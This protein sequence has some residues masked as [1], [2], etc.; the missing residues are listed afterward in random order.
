MP[1]ALANIVQARDVTLKVRAPPYLA[2]GHIQRASISSLHHADWGRGGMRCSFPRQ[3]L[4]CWRNA[5]EMPLFSSS[6]PSH[7]SFR[8]SQSCAPAL[9]CRANTSRSQVRVL[10]KTASLCKRM[11]LILHKSGL[12][13]ITHLYQNSADAYKG[14]A[15]F[16]VKGLSFGMQHQLLYSVFSNQQSYF[17]SN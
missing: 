9:A 14:Q 5:K 3:R 7:H 6:T 16:L 17:L 10:S 2:L 4:F 11:E 12:F 1:A 8:Q 15:I 13:C